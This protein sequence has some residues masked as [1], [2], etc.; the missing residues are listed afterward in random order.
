MA[1]D[2]NEWNWFVH[3]PTKVRARKVKGGRVYRTPFGKMWI[4]DD[5]MEIERKGKTWGNTLDEFEEN[6]GPSGD[7]D[8][9]D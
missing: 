1:N 8:E 9:Y 2:N 5:H 3:K 4:D 6:Y 7:K